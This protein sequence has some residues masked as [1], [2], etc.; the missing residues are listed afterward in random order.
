MKETLSKQSLLNWIFCKQRF[1]LLGI[2]LGILAIT[3]NV[4][5]FLKGSP[6]DVT[7]GQCNLCHLQITKEGKIPSWNTMQMLVMDVS[8]SSQSHDMGKGNHPQ[9]VSIL[10]LS[11]HDAM[12]ADSA[13]SSRASFHP[14]SF[15]YTPQ[16]DIDQN[17]F[18]RPK[19]IY[20][21]PE[22]KVILGNKSKTMYPLYG[23]KHDQIECPTCHNPH[24]AENNIIA[25]TYHKSLLRH[26]ASRISLCADCHTGKY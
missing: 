14:S 8:F 7:A 15:T 4:N 21:T 23:T 18:P 10:C 22:R 5:A 19:A 12:T 24:Y 13:R 17:E 9:G 20:E 26:G 3:E 1:L 2:V 11:C 25:G 6:H 16:R